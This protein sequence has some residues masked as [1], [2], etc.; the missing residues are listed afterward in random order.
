VKNNGNDENDNKEKGS[1]VDNEA[2]NGM[3]S[4]ENIVKHS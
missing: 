4:T 1:V 3:H 2:S